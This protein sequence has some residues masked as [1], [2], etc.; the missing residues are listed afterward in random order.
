MLFALL[1]LA[2]A[3]DWVPARWPSADPA[4]L[5][6]LKDT[7][8]NCLL[9]EPK[10]WS[11]AFNAEARKA[12]VAT[13]AVVHSSGE[14]DR[15]ASLGFSGV[16]LE[17]S[18]APA[19]RDRLKASGLTIVE[20]PPRTAMP[21]ASGSVIIGTTQGL[22][23]GVQSDADGKKKAAPSGAAWIDTNTGFLRFVSAASK[24]VMWLA[25]QPPPE[26]EIP[27]ERYLQAIGDTAMTGARWV[28]A[29]DPVFGR[30]LMAGDA[31]AVAGWKRIA[32]T[33][34][35]YE[36]HREWR[37]AQPFARLA[38]IQDQHSG[39]LLS[40]GVL[41][42][43]AVKHTPVRPVP[44]DRLEKSIVENARMAV[45]VDPAA[46]NDGQRD[47]LRAFTRAGGT[48]LTGPPG[49]KFP[50]P[51]PGQITLEKDDLGKLDEIW[52]ELNAMTGRRNLGA[53]LFNVSTMLS[54]L[55]ESPDHRYVYLQLVNYSDYPVENV[56]VHV[57]GT[58]KSIRLL[59][60]EGPPLSL[61][62]YETDE[63]TGIDIEQVGAVATI[64]LE[65]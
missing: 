16:V 5:G 17:G 57:L 23:P 33:L 22:W 4:T 58:Y 2:A 7:A 43:I 37:A 39:A 24:S 30:K 21:L 47:V 20:L 14:A 49:W 59:R 52:R 36:D 62:G 29:F 15:L 54:N 50:E 26:R 64:V 8:V 53:R 41:D 10:D 65:R 60:P 63:G 48:L 3:P 9:L 51:R 55:L 35:F 12:G 18:P 38:L 32:A 27:V 45:N 6:L 42:M 13:L 1:V 40:G 31:K 61:S 46:L 28:V 11:A 34:R 19:L 44:P 56:T 25:N